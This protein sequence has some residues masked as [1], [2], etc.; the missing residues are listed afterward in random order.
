[1]THKVFD[2]DP[3]PVNLILLAVAVIVGVSL[4]TFVFKKSASTAKA[5]LRAEAEA[6]EERLMP[7]AENGNGDVSRQD[8]G[9]I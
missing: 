8:Y 5:E 2:N 9:T 3:R 1:M 4:V 6:A 7:G